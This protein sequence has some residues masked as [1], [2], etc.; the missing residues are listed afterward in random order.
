MS[1]LPT[2]ALPSYMAEEKESDGI[3]MDGFEGE[4]KRKVKA[5]QE[6]GY[7]NRNFCSLC[8]QTS[9]GDAPMD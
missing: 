7:R 4:R 6:D 2:T 1:V 5:V 3:A 8:L 9:V